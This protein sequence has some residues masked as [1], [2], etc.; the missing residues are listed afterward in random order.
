MSN[1][2]GE[3]IETIVA[4]QTAMIPQRRDLF[5]AL[6]DGHSSGV[7]VIAEI[8]PVSP[9]DGGLM[10]D[11]VA[12]EDIVSAYEDGGAAGISVLIEPTHFGGSI[13][14]LRQVR[15]S[16]N[17]PVLAK[18]FILSPFHLAQCVAA[19]ADAFLL[20]VR[21]NESMNLDLRTMIELGRSFEMTAVVEAVN[22]EEVKKAVSAGAKIIAINCRNIYS[23]L[24]IDH[25]KI[26]I[27]R[28]IPN[29]I[30]LISASGISNS[31]DLRRVYELSH[32]RVDAVLVGTSLMQS[33]DPERAVRELVTVGRE[34]AEGNRR[35]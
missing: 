33:R 9:T 20:M 24:K 2:L 14:L 5:S 28:G 7:R 15:E 8:K 21:V 13:E 34:I 27:G 23:D 30:A 10:K 25:S 11:D 16:C 31:S 17:L 18:G 4:R 12:I 26:R 29:G 6:R 1:G 3:L 32:H 35:G 22:P 19:G